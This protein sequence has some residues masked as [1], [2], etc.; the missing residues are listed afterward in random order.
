[1]RQ[2]YNPRS[3]EGMTSLARGFQPRDR[4]TQCNA[5][6]RVARNR[7]RARCHFVRPYGARTRAGW[8]SGL[9]PR[10]KIVCTSGAT[11]R[12]IPGGDE[13]H[14]L[15]S[16]DLKFHSPKTFRAPEWVHNVSAHQPNAETRLLSAS[17]EWLPEGIQHHSYTT[18]KMECF[19][20][21][22]PH[23]ATIIVKSS[24]FTAR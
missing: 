22:P 15:G 13:N 24:I 21:H 1:M 2:I 6:R 12:T 20:I 16:D 10:A 5:P 19:L 3:P 14:S 9:K 23:P 8:L 4:I 18:G 11:S 17:I 7:C